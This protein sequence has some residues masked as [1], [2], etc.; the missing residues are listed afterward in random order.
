MA[1]K[2]ESEKAYI[3]QREEEYNEGDDSFCQI[4]NRLSVSEI[5]IEG[6][7]IIFLS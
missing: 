5:T 2:I 4:D 6:I 7:V 1:D 3:L